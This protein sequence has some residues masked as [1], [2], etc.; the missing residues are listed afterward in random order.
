LPA[1][2]APAHHSSADQI[3]ARTGNY[4]VC[5]TTGHGNRPCR[6]ILMSFRRIRT[7]AGSIA[8][9]SIAAGSI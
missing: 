9:G 8:A 2:D 5:V 7:T 1:T 4:P 3:Q 6:H